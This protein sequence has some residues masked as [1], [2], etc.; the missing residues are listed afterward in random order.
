VERVE[1]D[2]AGGMPYLI[3]DIDRLGSSSDD[4]LEAIDLVTLVVSRQSLVK[5]SGLRLED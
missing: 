2:A 5:T 1:Q 3:D 4:G